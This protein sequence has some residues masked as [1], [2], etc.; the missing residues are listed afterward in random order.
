MRSGES[1]ALNPCTS[2]P[3]AK[4]QWW[5]TNRRKRIPN[6]WSR[7]LTQRVIAAHC[8]TNRNFA[9]SSTWKDKKYEDIPYD[10]FDERVALRA[11]RDRRRRR[12]GR[13]RRSGQRIQSS[14]SLPGRAVDR[15]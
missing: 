8:L 12:S 4:P 14:L 7:Q 2:A 9:E 15:L 3:Q 13:H 10:S 11:A 5:I 1:T 6:N